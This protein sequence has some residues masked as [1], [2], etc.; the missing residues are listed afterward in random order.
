MTAHAQAVSSR[1]A[2]A[3]ILDWVTT[4]DHKKIGIMYLVLNFFFFII[5]GIEALL[6]RTQLAGSN[7]KVLDPQTYNEMFT[8]HGTTMIF[9]VLVPIWAGFAN[10]FVPLMIGARDMAFPRLNALSFWLLA[11]GGLV[12]Y[13]S[14]LF[15]GAD[16]R[17]QL[18]NAGWTSYP[19]LTGSLYS[20]GQNIDF[21]ILGLH[22]MGGS[23]LIGAINFLVTILNMRAPGM[24]LTD[25]PMFV[26]SM[27]VTS[28]M[29]LFA[30]PSLTVAISLL[31]ADRHFGTHFFMP[32]QGGDPL[33]WQNLFWFY[34]HPA[35]YIMV[36][37]GMGLVSELL[38]V[39]SRKPLFGYAFVAWS[40]V[41]IAVLGYSVWAHHM[42][43]VGSSL[44]VNTFFS[45]ASMI[46]AV[47]TGVKIFN[48]IGTL[49]GG[50][51]DMRAPMLF[52]IGFISMFIIGGLSGVML[53]SVPVNWQVHDTYFVVAHLHYVLFGGSVF[54]M[55]AGLYYWL[56]K[57]TGWRLQRGWGRAHFWLMLI[58]FNLTFFPMHLSGL[59][60]MPRRIYTYASGQG[61]EIWNLMSTIGAFLI[62][63]SVLVFL[64]NFFISARRKEPAGADPWGGASLEWATSSPPPAHNFDVVPPVKGRD[65][66]WILRDE[67]RGDSAPAAHG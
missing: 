30:T 19:P 55:F 65:P 37:P 6:V 29:V 36:L 9:L 47:P 35:V 3:E 5:G 1:N 50:A 10:Y 34:S 20:P 17:P 24:K 45:A 53:A 21:W 26:W 4:V 8:L 67:R 14:F 16:G 40:S 18:P 59:L 33:L 38:A 61:W 15:P 42:F 44:A 31:L 49:W 54:A 46:I 60:G 56:P 11:F 39:F 57:I 13:S 62:A 48:W 41:G 12:M 22:L 52:S 43:Q 2:L 66:L 23:S 28:T 32:A 7:L 25:L 58:G 63:A 64:I 51:L 27:M